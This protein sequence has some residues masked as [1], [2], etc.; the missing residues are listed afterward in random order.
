MIWAVDM[1]NY[2]VA[3]IFRPVVVLFMPVAIILGLL[4]NCFGALVT[5]ILLN[6]IL[7]WYTRCRQCGMSIYFDKSHPYRTLLG[8]PQRACTNCGHRQD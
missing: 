4:V 5:W 8:K 2:T 1:S 3:K 6:G 7:A